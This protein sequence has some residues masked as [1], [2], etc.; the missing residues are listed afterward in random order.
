MSDLP[1]IQDLTLAIIVFLS[2]LSGG[3]FGFLYGYLYGED[4]ANRKNRTTVY[5]DFGRCAGSD[6]GESQ[7]VLGWE[8]YGV[9]PREAEARSVGSVVGAGRN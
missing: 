2:A 3:I 6:T 4:H 5:T 9:L 8:S 7:S 1:A